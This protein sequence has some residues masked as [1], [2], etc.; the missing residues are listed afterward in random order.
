MGA[1]QWLVLAVALL[2][3]VELVHA[4]RN[5]RHL[6]ARGGVEAGA[7]H[8]P[9]LVALHAAWLIAIF[10]AVPADRPPALSFMLVFAALLAARAW[11]IWSLGPYWTTRLITLPEAPLVRRGPYRFMRHPNYAI[12]AGEIA[13]L[14]LIFGAWRIALVFSVLNAALLWHRIRVEDQALARRRGYR[15]DEPTAPRAHR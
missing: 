3:F 11:T 13:V 5:A 7:G 2:R 6:L 8:Y 15:P 12:V 1:A 4:R 9:L 14:P 10:V